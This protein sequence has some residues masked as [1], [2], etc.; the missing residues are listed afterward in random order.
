MNS[1]TSENSN[2]H[3]LLLNLSNKIDL[4]RVEKSH[5]LSNLNIYYTCKNKKLIKQQ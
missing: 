4:W 1:E 2:P 3:R 5:A